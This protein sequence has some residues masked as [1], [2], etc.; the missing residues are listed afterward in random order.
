MKKNLHINEQKQHETESFGDM[1]SIQISY[2]LY[3]DITCTIASCKYNNAEQYI[4][5]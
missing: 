4:T 5:S 1:W 3:N 2:R